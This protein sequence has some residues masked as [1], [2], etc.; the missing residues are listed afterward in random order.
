MKFLKKLFKA[1]NS[2]QAP[3][4]VTLA[5]A[6]G[7]VSGLTP[8]SGLQTVVILFL[9]FLLN[10]HLGLFFVAS[11][12]FAGI[13]YLFD[14]WFEQIGY[15][16]LNSDSLVGLWTT[17]YNSE[18]IRMS[19]FNNTLVL[20][21][22][23][24]S[25]VLAPPLYLFLGWIIRHYRETLSVVLGKYPRLGL[26]GILKTVPTKDPLIRW[27]GAGLFL[28]V[29]VLACVIALVFINPTAKWVMEKGGS[30]LLQRDVRVG[31]VEVGL[32][33]IAINRIEIA[34][35]KEGVDALSVEQT[36]FDL[37]LVALLM[38]RT[39]IE[40][41]SFIGLGL[42]TPA[43]LKKSVALSTSV[44]PGTVQSDD[45]T[46]TLPT[47]ELPTPESIMAKTDLESV[48][49]YHQ[50]EQEIPA[51]VAKWKQV[52]NNDFSPD[53]LEQLK[54]EFEALKKK[55]ESKDP[56]QML[57]LINQVPAFTTKLQTKQK[58]ITMLQ[59]EFKA[60]RQR[61]EQLYE[62]FDQASK[63]D[64]ERLKANYTLDN[65]GAM[66]V[67]GL[68]LSDKIK[69]YLTLAQRYY[70]K[71]A[72]YLKSEPKPPVPPRGEG[73]WMTFPLREARPELFIAKAEI[74]GIVDA[75]SFI[76]TAHDISDN[77]KAVGRP[78]SFEIKSE[79]PR[80]SSLSIRGED[81]RLGE[82]SLD[83]LNFEVQGLTLEAIN[84]DAIH[85]GQSRLAVGGDIA[86][87]AM[88]RLSGTN[89]LTFSETT[90][91]M[92][93]DTKTSR[94]VGDVLSSIKSFKASVSLAGT[95]EKPEVSVDTDLDQ[96]LSAA[97]S[98][99]L[100]KQATTFRNDLQRKLN[101]QASSQLKALK[102][103][104]GGLVDIN[105]LAV[106]QNAL[107]SGYLTEAGGLLG[108]KGGGGSLKGIL[109]F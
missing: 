64:F 21:S 34:S 103:S 12:F 70:T 60:D 78:I 63:A 85:F 38:N 92:S 18:V 82:Q 106:Q 72:P 61:I 4:Q 28:G 65:N 48:K 3:W 108:K 36:L 84:F 102:G 94:I 26:F 22:T 88:Q 10:I 81:N 76:L 55:S 97:V 51:L 53:E 30:R 89:T 33:V 1:L 11:A 75:Q 29:A 91:G 90:M 47:F 39:H 25:L 105:T 104:A 71:V 59:D 8:I 68:L 107:I 19:Y 52:A 13:G 79:G 37:D 50:G 41:L 45:R 16:L 80:I 20:G 77:Q 24:A 17:W 67:I 69:T 31:D 54:M 101:S 15:A 66:N 14:P 40:D 93:G 35:E 58:R 32:G 99:E 42:N 95:L 100:S 44:D 83:R 57:Q 27:W 2:A 62:K 5:I 109:P 6:S 96:K 74:N 49:V 7:M 43:T 86:L 23:L 73:R 98:G 87:E 56:Q 9:V 46:I